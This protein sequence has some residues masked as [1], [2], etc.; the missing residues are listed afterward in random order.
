MDK[1]VIKLFIAVALIAITTH[2]YAQ[3]PVPSDVGNAHPRCFG[4]GMSRESVHGLTKKEAWA[5][6]IIDKTKDR[7]SKY[8]SLCEKE[9]DWLRS[10]LQMYWKTKS[11]Q[12]YINGGVYDHAE[13]EAP[14]PTVKFIGGRG[15][16]TYHNRPKLEEVQPYMDDPRGLYLERKDEEGKWEWVAIPATGS[17]VSSINREILGLARDAAFLYWYTGEEQYATLA[18]GVLDT[19]LTGI[20]YLSEPVDLSR[21]HHQ[22]LVSYTQFEVIQEHYI[23]EVTQAYDFL[24]AH[25]AKRYPDKINLYASTL[26]KWAD[27]QIKNG[28][29]FNNWNIFQALHVSRIALVLENNA[30][31]E[32]GKGAQYYLD[33]IMNQTSTRQWSLTKLLDYGYDLNTGIWNESPGY[34]LGVLRDLI[35]LVEFYDRSFDIDLVAQLPVLKQAVISSVQYL[36]PNGWRVAFGDGHYGKLDAAPF[37]YMI[38]VA[39][40]YGR[41]EDEALFTKMLK[42]FFDETV[43]A[44]TFQGSNLNDLFSEERLNVRDDIPAGKP[45]DFT[46]PLF[47]A[48]NTSWL[49]QRQLFAAPGTGLMISQIGSLGNHM[50]ANG[51]AMELYGMGLPLAPEA[52]H[53][54]GYFSIDYAEYYTQFPAHNTVIVNGKSK[55][56]EMKSNHAFTVN[57]AYPAS[58]KQQGN[59]PGITFSDVSF[60]EPETHSDQ[61]RVMG[62]VSDGERGYYIDIFRSRQKEGKDVKHEYFY[63]NLGQAF[64]LKDANGS[65]LS[66]KPT[67]KMA[68]GDGDLMA[69]DYFWDK[70]SVAT[71]E[72]FTGVF[73]LT[74]DGKTVNMNVWGKGHTDRELFSAL[75]PKATSLSRG[76]LPREISELPVPTLVIRQRGEAWSKPF[77][78]VYEPALNG[79]SNIRSVDYFGEEDRVGIHVINTSG[80]EDFILSNTVH[81]EWAYGDILLKGTYAVISVLDDQVKML[82]SNGQSL[83]YKDY[84]LSADTAATLGFEIRNGQWYVMASTSARLCIVVDDIKAKYQLTD[85]N[86]KT[87]KGRIDK[88]EKH[89]CF[90]LPALDYTTIKM[91]GKK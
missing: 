40:K 82:M 59:F 37:R 52:G 39:R 19:Y 55:Y 69:Y 85:A 20:Y 81:D 38:E 33:Q 73:G 10:R 43:Y 48:P 64:A 6:R 72:D 86:G 41:H 76:I 47:Y 79:Q 45:E 13:G 83:R 46:A 44:G 71:S 11:K 3:L 2:G 49:V 5:R 66:L 89:V 23:A 58:A 50:H 1:G 35:H 7:L 16:K 91:E 53:G 75:S 68:F 78:M 57:A 87:Y 74:L 27:Q 84:T 26:Q 28:V 77:V 8:V 65:A 70:K 24:Y 31:Y 51:I 9:P 56:P 18:H 32:N 61:R 25:I 36:Y 17:I 22:T 4:K 15:T 21:G 14:A 80:K 30:A 63:H 90:D 34:A 29:S 67:T 12:V 62:I 54:S 60:L 88:K 42:T